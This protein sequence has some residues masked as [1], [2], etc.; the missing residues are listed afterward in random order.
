MLHPSGRQE[1]S[2]YGGPTATAE[3]HRPRV[4]APAACT[5]QKKMPPPA[6]ERMGCWAAVAAGSSNA[7]ASSSAAPLLPTRRRNHRRRAA[8]SRGSWSGRASGWLAGA[9]MPVAAAHTL[10]GLWRRVLTEPRCT[11]A[12]G[13]LFKGC[14]VVLKDDMVMPTAMQRLFQAEYLL[15]ARSSFSVQG[16]ERVLG[17]RGCAMEKGVRL[18]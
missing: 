2:S 4:L 17:R 14:A 8:T 15:C 5:H 6:N 10:R 1:L 12:R 13:W 16:F 3:P 9:A 7:A 11:D 18:T